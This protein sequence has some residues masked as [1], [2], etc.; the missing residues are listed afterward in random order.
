MNIAFRTIVV[1]LC[2]VGLRGQF[3]VVRHNNP[4]L[5]TDLG[6][7]LW[8]WPL[9]MDLDKDGDL[10]LVVSCSDK[11]YNGTYFFEN[12]SGGS[13]PV[14]EAARKIGPGFGNIQISYVE[15]GPRILVPGKEL[16]YT[17]EGGLVEAQTLPI[18]HNI[19]TPGHNIRAN[20]WSYVDFD[21]D[22]AL[23]IIVGVGDWHDYGW[24]DAFNQQGDWTNGPLR[25][26]IYLLH[27]TGSNDRP[28][29]ADPTLLRTRTGDP[30]EVFGRPSPN[31]ADFDGDGD[32]D[33]LCGEFLDSFTYFENQGTR[34]RPSFADGRPLQTQGQ[35][36]RMDLEMITP[37]AL[38]WDGDGDIDLIVG[39]EDGRVALVE[40]SGGLEGSMPQF[41]PPRYFQQK[42]DRVKFGALATP[43]GF[44]WDGDGDDD[45]VAGNTA[46][47]VAF[48]E[49]L[50]GGGRPRWA[51]PR[52]LEAGGEIIRIMA[53]PNGSIQG[54]AEAKW[55]YTTLSAA[56]W[57][58]DG[59]PDL[60]VNSIWGTVVW[61]RNVGSR[62]KP[63]L[64]SGRDVEVEWQ[65][66]APKPAWLWWTPG[67]RQLVTQWRT[68]PAV[69]DW[70][71]DG[72]NDLVMLDHEGYLALFARSRTPQGLQLHPG[73]RVFL[74]ESG[75]PLQ[76]N[77]GRA[78]KSG[79]R[80]IQVVDWDGD[81]LKDIL[82]N[83]QNA[84]LLRNLGEEGRTTRFRNLG[85]VTEQK[86]SGHST[87][88]TVVDWDSNG[89]PDLL[90]GTESGFF[91]HLK[92]PRK[93]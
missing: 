16:R 39:D 70:N 22:G 2:V 71:G 53:G 37:V 89:V 34:T 67:P 30:I 91:Y 68:T 20:Q 54:P 19:H 26:L 11:P 49:N 79:R 85:P 60:I 74:D 82:I 3:E 87:S 73:Q 12:T 84:D 13:F 7:G 8:A 14:F 93:Q 1:L 88:P 86:L 52:Y 36:L 35:P 48:I 50:G 40:N 56:D 63:R 18:P 45:L 77:S 61:Y 76:L 24:D 64:E 32:L 4:G 10:D 44:D 42:A 29:Y 83:S 5:V 31:F 27:N 69:V 90:L 72:L 23:D 51:A 55:G 46:G 92:N 25:G 47:Y 80:K 58:A 65:G 75:E 62:Q 78:G 57:D 59:L 38:D 66:K 41:R 15:G 21:G 28:V 6:V 43:Y 17:S 9:P 33:L 81:G